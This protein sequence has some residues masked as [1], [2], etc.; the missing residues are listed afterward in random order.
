MRF[1]ILTLQAVSPAL[2]ILE[3]PPLGPQAKNRHFQQ[4]SFSGDSLLFSF[5]GGINLCC[6]PSSNY[7]FKH[8]RQSSCAYDNDNTSNSNTNDDQSDDKSNSCAPFLLRSCPEALTGFSSAI[9][10]LTLSF[11]GSPLR[12]H[13]IPDRHLSEVQFK[14]NL[15]LQ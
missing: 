15:R 5:P 3:A 10:N 8:T 13:F 9:W 14:L 6:A 12:I 11:L 2:P 4:F 7:E 1:A